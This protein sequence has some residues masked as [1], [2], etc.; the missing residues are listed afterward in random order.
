[1]AKQIPTKKDRGVKFAPVSSWGDDD[2][3]MHMY[4]TNT[5]YLNKHADEWKPPF[6]EGR[7]M[8][9]IYS[10]Q[11][12]WRI[13]EQGSAV[14]QIPGRCYRVNIQSAAL[15]CGCGHKES[16]HCGRAKMSAPPIVTH[17]CDVGA[18]CSCKDFHEQADV[19]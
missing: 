16:E 4:E 19:D 18:S 12:H 3:G 1:M 14:C 13:V 6:G 8:H 9:L 5:D 7:H 11:V 2:Y 17:P 15:V 10:K